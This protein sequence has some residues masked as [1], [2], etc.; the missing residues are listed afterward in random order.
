MLKAEYAL[1]EVLV[2]ML[3]GLAELYPS[4]HFDTDD[5]NSYF[6]SL[7]GKYYDW[8]RRCLE[9]SGIG[10]GGTMV[11]VLAAEL[12]VND[13]GKMV[14]EMSIALPTMGRGQSASD[15]PERENSRM[16]WERGRECWS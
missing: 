15:Q 9:P 2:G 4:E 12:T 6:V 8:H 10:T 3:A 14:T 5:P 13:L 1:M 16:L 11:P 7:S